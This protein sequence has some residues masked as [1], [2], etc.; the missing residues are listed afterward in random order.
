M[1][2]ATVSKILNYSCVDGPGNRMVLFLQGCNY[3]CKIVITRK[4]LICVINVVIAFRVV[5]RNHYNL[6]HKTINRL[7]YGK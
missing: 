7:L 1:I 4:Q 6:R 2:S 5:Q 3:R